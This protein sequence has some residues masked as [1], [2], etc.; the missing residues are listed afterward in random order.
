MHHPSRQVPHHEM[1]WMHSGRDDPLLQRHRGDNIEVCTWLPTIETRDDSSSPRFVELR[2]SDDSS[3]NRAELKTQPLAP[4]STVQLNLA[5]IIKS[6]QSCLQPDGSFHLNATAS[7]SLL[8]LYSH[9]KQLNLDTQN[10][11]KMGVV[12]PHAA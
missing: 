7:H 10:D 11:P 8:E 3:N 2:S 6:M 5:A 9:L 4:T 12:V 1:P